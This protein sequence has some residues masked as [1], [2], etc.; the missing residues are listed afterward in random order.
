MTV[1]ETIYNILS[2][3]FIILILLILFFGQNWQA[4]R[5]SRQIRQSLKDL[6]QWRL[7]GIKQI[8]K[9]IEPLTSE[10]I[11]EA[12]IKDFITELLDYF[13]IPF[14]NFKKDTYILWLNLILQQEEHL[15]EMIRNYVPKISS[16]VLEKLLALL[17]ATQ[18]IDLILKNGYH[19]LSI[20]EKTNGYWYLLQTASEITQT[21]LKART[22][23][24][25]IDSIM[26]GEPIGD[27]IAP[28]VLKTF[29][30]QFDIPQKDSNMKITEETIMDE[31][32]L[33]TI[34]FE[35]RNLV[36]L[37]P[38]GPEPRVGHPGMIVKHVLENLPANRSNISMILTID[39]FAKLEVEK[40]GTISHGLGLVIGTDTHANFEKAYLEEILPQ[41]NPEIKMEAIICRES[42]E[43]AVFPMSEQIKNSIAKIIRLIKSSIITQSKPGDNI[44]ILASGNALGI[45]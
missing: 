35:D 36:C 22:Y 43:D 42:L 13:I 1:I 25:L 41:H 6:K 21:M 39:A 2:S 31:Y 28:L 15:K 8:S 32:L 3:L 4:F 37:R 29:I 23:R 5:A 44:I 9:L 10:T 45:S 27:S 7:Y 17:K 19:N 20:G 11:T 33:N 16:S 12:D 18:Q 38:K 40:S 26:L 24:V 34:Q 30:E 14:E